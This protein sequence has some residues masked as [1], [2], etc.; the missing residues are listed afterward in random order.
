[1]TQGEKIARYNAL[2]DALRVGAEAV[3]DAQDHPGVTAIFEAIKRLRDAEPAVATNADRVDYMARVQQLARSAYR[4]AHGNLPAR[5]GVEVDATASVDTPLGRLRLTTWERQVY[6]KRG[7]RRQ[8]AGEYSLDDAPITVAE[9][10]AA[11]LAPR[12]TTRNRKNA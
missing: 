6:G 7:K 9:I 3:E 10:R 8:W 1:M 12:P 11:N 4:E 2:T 5:Y